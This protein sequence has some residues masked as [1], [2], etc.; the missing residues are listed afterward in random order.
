MTSV[1]PIAS[2]R[3]PRKVST[4]KLSL[5]AWNWLRQRALDEA[6]KDGGRP[7]ASAIVERLIREESARVPDEAA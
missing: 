5:A 1:A 7:S 2:A 3:F 4:L 6:E